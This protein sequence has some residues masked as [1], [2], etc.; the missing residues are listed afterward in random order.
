M[1]NRSRGDF[2]H[3]EDKLELLQAVLDASVDGIVTFDE[4]GVIQSANLS[5]LKMFGVSADS[6]VGKPVDRLLPTWSSDTESEANPS[7]LAGTPWPTVGRRHD[8]S[9]FSLELR[10]HET[11]LD[12]R[13]IFV[14]IVRDTSEWMAAK[15]QLGRLATLLEY[16]DDAIKAFDPDGNITAWNPGAERLYG[17]DEK[18][19]L[20]M[21]IREIL[22][23]D[24][25]DE[26]QNAIQKLAE[27]RR[28]P[29]FETQRVT[30][31]GQLIDVLSTIHL[32][33]GTGPSSDII[34]ATDRDITEWNRREAALKESDAKTR[35]IVEAAVDGIITIDERGNIESVNAAAESLF[36]YETAE[37]VGRNVSM[38]M[39]SPY[40]EEHDG[41]MQRYIRSGVK[42]IIGIGRE[43]TGQRKDGST[44][45]M[46]L[47]ISELTVNDKTMF[48]G[49]VR[50]ISERKK[51]QEELKERSKSIARTNR[52]LT[53]ANSRAEEATAAKSAFLA[54]MSHEIRTPMTAILGF[55]ELLEAGD[56]S[57]AEEQSAISTI[58]SNGE[59][60]LS[61]LND[62][63]DLSKV[64]AGQIEMERISCSPAQIT[65]EVESLLRVRADLK[66]LK[67]ETQWE[68]SIPEQI[69]SDPTRI[70]QVLVNLVGNAIKFTHQGRVTVSVAF[71]ETGGAASLRF[72]VVDTGI[73]MEP[74]QMAKIFEPFAQ[75]DATTTRVYGGTGL[76]LTISRR[77][78]QLLG[79]ELTATSEVGKGSCFEFSFAP[80]VPEGVSLI[81]RPSAP[82]RVEAPQ[83]RT[84]SSDAL[85]GIRIL[86]AED[87]EINQRLLCHILG[88]AGATVVTAANGREAVDQAF[89]ADGLTEA[90]DV[91]LMDMQM[92]VMD[93]YAA[94]AALR[95][96]GYNGPILA[97]TANAMSGDRDRCLESGCSD[98]ATK[99]IER[100]R[101]ISTIAEL[102]RVA[103]HRRDRREPDAA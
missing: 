98:Y 51:T 10:V 24:R 29:P 103:S 82:K 14:G 28:I 15:E 43:V 52:I 4:N 2:A 38:L 65:H 89:E 41:Y 75:A 58:R 80:E 72:K 88:R 25:A 22:P 67:L 18:T 7:R 21:N 85:S 3:P 33:Q 64:E 34:V 102:A 78:V 86:V 101:L 83:L 97:L 87:G 90:F 93:G 56:L 62:I 36:G 8:G 11:Q 1:Q 6:V 92:P 23:R 46:D 91:I 27:G 16:S 68:T 81:D 49:I 13:R 20:S 9:E 53:E 17:Y 30:S 79:G 95:K 40:R 50:D 5:A 47:A 48:T 77:I 59:Y 32:I 12:D 74:D 84:P 70:R 37:M 63:L 57:Q 54:N 42:K 73:G 100:V 99:P 96:R 76:G 31:D 61:L 55:T 60:L 69:V 19:A 39:P 44:F 26:V 71:E 66:D 35:A 94:T 45:P